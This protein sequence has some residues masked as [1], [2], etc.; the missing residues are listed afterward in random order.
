MIVTIGFGADHFFD[1]SMAD[2]SVANDDNVLFH[3]MTGK[4]VEREGSVRL[5]NS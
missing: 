1:K 5:E 4:S 3:V 2:H